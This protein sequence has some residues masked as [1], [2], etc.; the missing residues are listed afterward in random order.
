[1]GYVPPDDGR[2]LGELEVSECVI[3]ELS[4]PVH[5]VFTRNSELIEPTKTVSRCDDKFATDKNSQVVPGRLRRICLVDC[6][7]V[8]CW[9]SWC[10]ILSG[11]S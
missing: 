6:C 1:M 3:F 4:P 11:V 10:R 9:S 7:R 2:H 5:E 8:F